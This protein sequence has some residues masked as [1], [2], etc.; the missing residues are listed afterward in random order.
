LKEQLVTV[1]ATSAS[2]DVVKAAIQKTGKE[3]TSE[4]DITPAKGIKAV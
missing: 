3:I 1:K 4:Q 2:I